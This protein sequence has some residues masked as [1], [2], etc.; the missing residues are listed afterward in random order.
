MWLSVF[1]PSAAPKLSSFRDA[2]LLPGTLAWQRNE[3]FQEMAIYL[4]FQKRKTRLAA[5]WVSFR[6]VVGGNVERQT[7]F[8][9]LPT[10]CASASIY[11]KKLLIGFS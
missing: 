9:L 6:L 11:M 4:V 5:L 2:V 10:S 8:R 1:S 3:G 7:S